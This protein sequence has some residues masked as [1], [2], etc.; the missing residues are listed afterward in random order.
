MTGYAAINEAFA[1]V[2]AERIARDKRWAE[3]AAAKACPTC[4]D[5]RAKLQSSAMD[6]LAID[7]QAM[8]L[9]TENKRLKDELA[10]VEAQNEANLEAELA[11]IQ[12][13]IQATA[14]LKADRTRLRTVLT[15]ISRA[16]TLIQAA[17]IAE[18]ALRGDVGTAT[19]DVVSYDHRDTQA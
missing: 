13:S 2:R 9:L 11:S 19:Q 17:Q 8:D 4:A 14:K 3:E 1:Q 10:R 12:R 5:L 15:A 6:C 18:G 7:G 16:T